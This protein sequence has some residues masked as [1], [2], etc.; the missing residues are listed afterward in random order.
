M[1]TLKPSAKEELLTEIPNLPEYQGLSD[2]MGEKLLRQR[3][4]R[5]R[6]L[7]ERLRPLFVHT[8][9]LADRRLAVRLLER[10][11][12]WS[13]LEK[14]A[15]RNFQDLRVKTSTWRMNGLSPG[16]EGLKILQVTDLHLDFDPGVIERVRSTVEELPYDLV[17]ITGDFFDLVFSG[18][19]V[20]KEHLEQLVHCFRSPVYA[21][22][23]NHD[24]LSVGFFL[25][26]L[27]V[28]VLMNESVWIP[29]GDGGVWLAGVDDAR[30]FG[31]DSFENAVRA[32]SWDGPVV[33]LSH[34]PQNYKDAER[35]GINLMLSGHTHGGQV[36]LPCG[37]PITGSH[38]CPLRMVSGRWKYKGLQG[39][40]SNGC[41][42]CKLPFRLNAPA[43]VTLHT[44]V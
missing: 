32:I 39:Y 19:A 38:G 24:V 4:A 6:L 31:T 26:E 8:D 7:R 21:V 41:G 44:L 11:V 36:S 27:G 43:E 9:G 13:G 35:N 15:R 29:N 40:T 14:R 1:L 37:I 30:Q 16:A 12:R 25:E 42:G 28:R 20:P 23:G 18:E 17:C 3:L 10:M 5:E 2:R 34:S 22:L 33:G